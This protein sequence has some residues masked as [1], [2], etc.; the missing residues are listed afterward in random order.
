MQKICREIDR[1]TVKGSIKPMRLYTITIDY[2]NLE[3]V[4]DPLLNLPIKEK[5][6]IRDKIRKEMFSK[7]T[8]GS[9]T[10][11]E[12]V[13]E[14][15]DFIELRQY[16]DEDFEK[17]FAIAYKAYIRGDWHTAGT[18]LEKLIEQRSHDGPTKNLYRIVV[19]NHNKEA[20]KDWKGYR[21]LTSK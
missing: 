1:V 8:G 3:P 20:P 15:Q 16:V 2:D 9:V 4:D 6:S 14:D 11:Y 12:E 5:K 18:H 10:T 21:A 7:L 13:S 17:T 19:K